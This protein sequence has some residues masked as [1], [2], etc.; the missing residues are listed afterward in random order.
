MLNQATSSYAL[1]KATVNPL[2]QTVSLKKLKPLHLSTQ[3]IAR[4]TEL[5]AAVF[6][7]K[8]PLTSFYIH[9]YTYKIMNIFRYSIRF[10]ICQHVLDLQIETNQAAALNK[11]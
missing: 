3:F 10:T 5:L 7:Y 6:A 11:P 1:N 9:Y 2:Q 4:G 8:T